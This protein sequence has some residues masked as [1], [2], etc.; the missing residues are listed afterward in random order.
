MDDS[1]SILV[2]ANGFKQILFIEKQHLDR[3]DE[4][5]KMRDAGADFDEA[6]AIHGI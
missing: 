1:P 4:V 5:R 2:R 6:L 3:Y